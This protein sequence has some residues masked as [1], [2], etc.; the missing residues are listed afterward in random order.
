MS[1]PKFRPLHEQIRAN[2]RNSVLLASMLVL[3]LTMLGVGIGW[4][5]ADSPI[6][7][8]IVAFV[9]GLALVVFART[10]GTD[11]VLKINGARPANRS[12][13]MVL[14][15][16]VE[17]VS[18][19]AGIPKPKV[20]VIEDSSMNAFATGKDPKNGVVAI[21]SGLMSRLNRDELQAV[22]AHEV[23]H[24]RNNDIQFMTSIA[25]LAGVIPMISDFFLRS[26]FYGGRRRSSSSSQ[27]GGA[28]VIL[29]LIALALA[30]LAPL[31]ALLIKLAISRQRE[32]LADATAA[33]L[34]RNPDALISA[35]SKLSQ[36]PNQLQRANRATEHMYIV[37]PYIG[38]EDRGSALFST[39]P[40]I[41]DRIRA[42]RQATGL[43]GA[44][45]FDQ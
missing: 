28:E 35:L 31:F 9:S 7:G 38:H 32:Y 41:P 3:L 20:Y 24:V 43:R 15:N 10:R 4:Y 39:H 18:I 13:E 42:I 17:E 1:P 40:P 21:T 34:T 14:Q 25:I 8:G 22:M 11:V 12:E 30:I 29:M 23:A 44:P 16:V 45:V 33:Q 26:M 2:A 6:I 27:G 36:D 19:A 5:W 37:N